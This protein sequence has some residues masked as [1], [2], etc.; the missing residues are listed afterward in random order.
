MPA[1]PGECQNPRSV[2]R[3]TGPSRTMLA[4]HYGP[5]SGATRFGHE[6]DM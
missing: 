5:G 1:K 2:D 6:L 3:L 4:V